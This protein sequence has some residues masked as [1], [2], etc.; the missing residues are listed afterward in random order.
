MGSHPF[1]QQH[2]RTVPAVLAAHWSFSIG[3]SVRH[4]LILTLDDLRAFPSEEWAC[5]VACAARRPLVGQAMWR[6]V[7][8]SA[9]LA[10][11]NID[12]SA[13]YARVSSA[14]GYSASLTLPQLRAALL[15]YEMDGQPLPA[16]HGYPARL[17][18]PGLYGYKMP[19][20]VTHIRLNDQ[21]APGYW[22]A[23][24]WSEDG[25][26]RPLAAIQDA[27]PASNG[28]LLIS[29]VAYAGERGIAAVEISLDDGDWTPGTL[30]PGT[31]HEWTRWHALWTPTANGDVVCRVR[32][33]D[34]AGNIQPEPHSTILRIFQ[35]RA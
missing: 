6:G 30:T 26:V 23:R 33:I 11:L 10:E 15:V 31:A 34:R 28:D 17:I 24:G 5:V 32:A 25:Y 35:E 7:P 27:Q 2:I 20:W 18:A 9:L 14:D 3:G 16:E 19:K 29:G 12:P 1:F 21:P 4:P 8:L 13:Q 22:E